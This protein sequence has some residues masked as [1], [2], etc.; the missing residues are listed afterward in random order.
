MTVILPDLLLMSVGIFLIFTCTFTNMVIA[1][2][3]TAESGGNIANL[4]F[5]LCLAF[6]GVLATPQSMPGL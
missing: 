3:D 1:G 6:C 4:M 5:M 2:V